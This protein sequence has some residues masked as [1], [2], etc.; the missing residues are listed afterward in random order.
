M[1][2]RWEHFLQ[3][4]TVLQ[5]APTFNELPQ[6][7]LLLMNSA[8]HRHMSGGY[9]PKTFGSAFGKG[10]Y[11]PPLCK[12]PIQ[13]PTPPKYSSGYATGAEM[14]VTPAPSLKNKKLF[15]GMFNSKLSDEFHI[16]LLMM[17]MLDI[18]QYEGLLEFGGTHAMNQG[19]FFSF[20]IYGARGRLF[21]T[22]SVDTCGNI[23]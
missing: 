2:N 11:C 22:F 5:R 10:K 23:N 9:T 7:L 4:E 15:H 8:K 13:P 12:V 16:L 20:L 1:L 14:T 18:C 21:S 19:D 6:L 3:F 17:E